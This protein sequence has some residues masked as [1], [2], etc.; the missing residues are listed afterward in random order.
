MKRSIRLLIVISLVSGCAHV[1]SK[2][3]RDAAEKAVPVIELFRNP[4]AYQGRIFI[5]GGTIVNSSNSPEGTYIEVIEK[6]LDYRGRP[7]HTD[8][9]RGRFIVLYEGYLDP[10]IFSSG[11][12]ITVAGEVLGT[13]V[14]QL[15]QIEYPYLFM[16]SRGL[17]LLKPE[18]DLPV[19]FGI[20]IWHSF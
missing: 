12:A 4:V 2:D 5:L 15:G 17:Y 13:K 8:I 10:S 11:R 6:P 18:Y 14:R 7:E 16:K 20:G 9:S 3:L 19:H 1:V